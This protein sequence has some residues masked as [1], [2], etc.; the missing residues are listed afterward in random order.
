MEVKDTLAYFRIIVNP[1]DDEAFKRI[2]NKPTRGISEATLN[3]MLAHGD[4]L[5]NT[6]FETACTVGLCCPELKPAA[7]KNVSAFIA[8][9]NKIQEECMGLDA[10]ESA[11]VILERSGLYEHYQNDKNEDGQKRTENIDELMNSISYFIQDQQDRYA[12]GEGTLPKTKLEDYLEDIALLS[13]IDKDTSDSGESVSLMTSH[14]SK[15]LEFDTV[16]VAGVEEG[17]YPSIRED[18]SKFEL[19]EERRLFY[20]SIT[21]AKR[22]LILTSCNE[23][24]KYNE[25]ISCEPSRFIEEMFEYLDPDKNDDLPE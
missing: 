23:R 22:E 13:R 17:L 15:G 10:F 25:T 5:K 12:T 6:L 11:K 2:C 21:R 16:F 24:W 18:N 20:V 3:T 4:Q 8:L 9:I 19:E 7:Q 1:Y 14:S